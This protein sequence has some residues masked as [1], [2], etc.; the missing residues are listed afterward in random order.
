MIDRSLDEYIRGIDK[1]KIKEKKISKTIPKIHKKEKI[2]E[3]IIENQKEANKIEEQINSGVI[4]NAV[5]K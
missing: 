5:L 2:I 3:E 1:I 4:N